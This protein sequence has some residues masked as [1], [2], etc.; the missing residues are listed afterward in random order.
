MGIYW[1]VLIMKWLYLW[2]LHLIKICLLESDFVLQG[3]L[4][5][6]LVYCYL[7]LV[8][9]LSLHGR[10][11]LVVWLQIYSPIWNLFIY[12][13]IF[14]GNL[15]LCCRILWVIHAIIFHILKSNF[16][17]P[18]FVATSLWSTSCEYVL[19]LFCAGMH[20]LLRK[21]LIV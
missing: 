6:C 9:M 19:L 8:H 21:R 20:H 17:R 3:A 2:T 5:T 7:F 13:N 10:V 14:D 1:V 18:Y 12:I 15:W 16:G 4:N 11:K